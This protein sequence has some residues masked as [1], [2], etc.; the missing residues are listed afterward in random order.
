MAV[1]RVTN[2][3]GLKPRAS[4]RALPADAA[5]TAPRIPTFNSTDPSTGMLG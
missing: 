3:G 4:A 2:F 1:L 5:Q